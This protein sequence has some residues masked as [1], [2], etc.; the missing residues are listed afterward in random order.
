MMLV[1]RLSGDF[2][3]LRS[4]EKRERGGRR[5]RRKRGGGGK[6]KRRRGEKRGEG[7]EGKGEARFYSRFFTDNY[8]QYIDTSE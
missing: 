2:L 5:R 1:N 8:G 7:K 6:G 4:P 3:V